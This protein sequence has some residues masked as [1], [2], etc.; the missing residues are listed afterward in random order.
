MTGGT[1]E[2]V[3]AFPRSVDA[4]CCGVPPVVIAALLSVFRFG[5][6]DDATHLE[7]YVCPRCQDLATAVDASVSAD[8]GS[9]IE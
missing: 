9:V 8:V 2:S 5:P 7:K 3:S 4:D 1:T 6:Q